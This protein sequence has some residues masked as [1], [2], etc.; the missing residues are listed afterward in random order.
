MRTTGLLT[1]YTTR[2]ERIVL[3]AVHSASASRSL[4]NLCMRDASELVCG[5]WATV[6]C[7]T[8][9]RLSHPRYPYRATTTASPRNASCLCFA[10]SLG[11]TQ[12]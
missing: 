7:H 3:A 4:P 6:D 8:H 11:V 1:K 10:W 2:A 5:P 9:V 12:Y